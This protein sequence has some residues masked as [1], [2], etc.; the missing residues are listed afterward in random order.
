MTQGDQHSPLFKHPVGRKRGALTAL[1][2][3]SFLSDCTDEPEPPR[4]KAASD[5]ATYE[6]KKLRRREFVL[7]MRS[8]V[9]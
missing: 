3:N 6:E 5:K 7:E 4:R 1:R 2:S 9:L 8:K